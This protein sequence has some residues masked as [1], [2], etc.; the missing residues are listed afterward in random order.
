VLRPRSQGKVIVANYIRPR[1][2]ADAPSERH[3]ITRAHHLTRY[4][5][6]TVTKAVRR[7]QEI[8]TSTCGDTLKPYEIVSRLV[9]RDGL[10]TP[11]SRHRGGLEQGS[12]GTKARTTHDLLNSRSPKP[13][14]PRISV[15]S[16]LR[17]AEFHLASIRLISSMLRAST[18]ALRPQID[19]MLHSLN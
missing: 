11:D 17:L 9:R 19:L 6:S 15:S 8:E 14:L 1:D 13:F 5:H 7:A 18:A 16:P 4:L 10:R 12:P 3:L 2:M